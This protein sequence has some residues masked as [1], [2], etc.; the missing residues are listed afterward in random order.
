[1][2]PLPVQFQWYLEETA[3]VSAVTARIYARQLARLLEWA[4]ERGR[5]IEDVTIEDAEAS[6]PPGSEIQ[7]RQRVSVFK[8]FE[9]WRSHPDLP[10]PSEE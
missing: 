2:P 5:A 4:A 3:G 9:Y 1:V 7:R 6:T 8:W 10:E